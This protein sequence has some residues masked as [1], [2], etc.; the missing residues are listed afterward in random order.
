MNLKK[1]TTTEI[2]HLHQTSQ[3]GTLIQIQLEQEL[4]R[5]KKQQIKQIEYGKKYRKNNKEKIKL[6]NYIQRENEK[7]K[8]K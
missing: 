1:H 2:K 5:R 4:K 7:E 8:Y 3:K 6:I